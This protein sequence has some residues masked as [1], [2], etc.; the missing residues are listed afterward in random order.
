MADGCYVYELAG[1]KPSDENE[2]NLYEILEDEHS[3][4][5]ASLVFCPSSNFWH[6]IVLI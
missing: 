2:S 6:C 5:Y 3:V 1:D 4:R